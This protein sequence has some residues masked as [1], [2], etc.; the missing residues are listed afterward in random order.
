MDFKLI[1]LR[2]NNKIKFKIL[3]FRIYSICKI[4]Y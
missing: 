4:P 3:T 1:P 2:E